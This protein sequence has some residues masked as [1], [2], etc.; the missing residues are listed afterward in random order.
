MEQL[1]PL[2]S[3]VGDDHLIR[4]RA[5]RLFTYLKELT[6]LR[7]EVK[8][9]CEEYEQVI[10][11]AEIPRENECYC[12]F[13]DLG[14]EGAYE[15]WIRVQRPR[16]KRPPVP[17]SSLAPWLSKRE[18]ADS[19]LEAPTLRESI[20]EEINPSGPGPS[21]ERETVV[22]RLEDFPAITRQWELYVENHWWPWALEDRRQQTIQAIYNDLFAAYQTQERLG[23]AFE[24]VVGVGLLTWKPPHGP[25]V[26]R[27]VVAGQVTV[28]FDSSTGSISVAPAA[29]GIRLTLE[30][31][32]LDPQDRPLP[33]IQNQLQQR[34]GDIGDE[35]WTESGLI[36]VLR[37]YFQQLSP[38][39]SLEISI[40][41]ADVS[42]IRKFGQR[43]KWKGCSLT[44]IKMAE[45]RSNDDATSTP[46]PHSS[47]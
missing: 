28:E 13:W 44:A 17:P 4:D 40:E 27:H 41:P 19:S 32:M 12:A 24:T 10:W 20:I 23:E 26:R 7:S 9:N 45:T 18:I 35:V 42:R 22:R 46:E 3:L 16:R 36:N 8:R 6:E 37:E 43:D 31:E 1:E 29:E 2:S 33:E 30:Q 34:L 39:N 14:R 38:S 25:E 5:I 21:N 47:F 11:W 15:D